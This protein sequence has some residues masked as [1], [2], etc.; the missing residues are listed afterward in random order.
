M[1]SYHNSFSYL[2][3]NSQDDLGWIITHFDADSGETDS[4]LSQEQVYT[5]SYNGSKRILYG[6]RWNSNAIVKI[7]VIKQSGASFS[8]TECREAYRWLTGN[9]NASWLDLYAGKSPK[10]GGK[11]KYSFLGTVQDVKPEKMDA[12]TIG[13]N[14]YFEST[15]PWAYSSEKQEFISYGLAQNTAVTIDED[16]VLINNDSTNLLDIDDDNVLYSTESENGNLNI[17]DD[18][19]MYCNKGLNVNSEGVLYGLNDI[20]AL[21]VDNGVV[22]SNIEPPVITA[23][24]VLCFKKPLMREIYNNTDDLYSYVYPDVKIKSNG[25]DYI[26][27]KNMTL[28]EE[29]IITGI[30]SYETI[31]LTAGQFILSDIPNKLFGNSFNFVWPRLAPDK[32]EFVIK[33]SGDIDITFIYRYPIKIGGCAIDIDVSEGGLCCGGDGAAGGVISGPVSWDDITDTPT[34]IEGYGI[35]NAYNKSEVDS[36]LGNADMSIDEQELNNMLNS[37]LGT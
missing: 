16:G 32:N 25:G 27:I 28:D 23:T 5:D 6:T 1:S 12:R 15:S 18:G 33:C 24:G 9:P 22:Y 13:L 30:K 17:G 21:G 26:Y 31:N 2:N 14:I 20:V 10:L 29:T 37:I 7:T 3:K 8:V 36:K 34:T 4:Y 19:S 35:T 11:P